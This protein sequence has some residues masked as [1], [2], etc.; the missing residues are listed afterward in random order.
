MPISVPG[1]SRSHHLS[2]TGRRDAGFSLIELMVVIAII[3]IATAAVGFGALERPSQALHNDARRLIQLFEVAHTEARAA[4]RPVVWEAD[5]QG[6]RF[7]A[8]ASWTPHSAQAAITTARADRYADDQ[9][10]RPRTWEAGVV[11]VRTTPAGAAV[12]TT[13]WIPQPMQ[14]ELT[15]SGQTLTI[16]RDAAGHYRVQQ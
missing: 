15:G 2:H 9:L 6:Y 7:R 13:E 10:L 5:A 3:G 1:R 12:F 8:R 16:L 14:I 4:G 11:Q